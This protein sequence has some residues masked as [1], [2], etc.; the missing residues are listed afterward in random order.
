MKFDS[1]LV[2]LGQESRNV[3]IKLSPKF[4]LFVRFLN[5]TSIERKMVN[6]KP[7]YRFMIM[8]TVLDKFSRPLKLS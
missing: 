5:E 4:L 6:R 7:K 1:N 3:L 2:V 8:W